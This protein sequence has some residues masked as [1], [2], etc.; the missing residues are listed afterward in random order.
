M[1][2]RM[3]IVD[4]EPEIAEGIQFLIQ[5]LCSQCRVIDLAYDGAEG[6]EKAVALRPDIILTD[7]RMPE[8]DG[9]EMI[10]RLNECG[11]AAKY[12]VLSGYAEFEYA[13]TAITLGVR[14]FITKP[15]EEQ[16][17]CSV[18]ARICEE[19]GAEQEK[20]EKVQSMKQAVS[21][22]V[23][24]DFLE[25]KRSDPEKIKQ[26]LAQSGFPL[27]GTGYFCLAIET[28]HPP[29][30]ER[31]Q[32]FLNLAGN[33]ALKSLDL[34][35]AYLVVEYTSGTAVLLGAADQ[36]MEP[37]SLNYAVDKFRSELADQLGVLPG[38]GMGT[39]HHRISDLPSSLE[40]ARCALNYKILKGA[41]HVITYSQIQD[42]EDKPSLISV[43]DMKRLEDCIDRLDDIGCKAVVEEIFQK[44]NNVSEL[45]L[46][47]L[48]QLSLNLVLT[49]LRKIPFVQLRLNRYLG[50][51]ILSLDSISK[52]RTIEQLQNWIVNT[53][54]SMNEVMLKDNLPEKRDVIREAKEYIQ[55]NFTRE[56][57]L[58]EI[59]EQFFI[60]PY[61][62]SQLFKRKTGMTYQNY[63]ISLRVE[64]A[65]K[66]LAETD[67][68]IY[69]ICEMV[70]Y[71]NHYHFNKIFERSEGVRPN[72]WRRRNQVIS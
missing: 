32:K 46:E 44:I 69:E 36:R 19:L 33:R 37:R 34:L 66:L 59:S 23:L 55:K 12:I 14:E 29:E 53:L 28:E 38:I 39:L 15:V 42:I 48:Q 51:N 50:R 22:Y 72:E 54:R 70:G 6:Y 35:P 43:N 63:L 11:F 27:S 45:N 9:L 57:G 64:R 30:E 8:A 1:S 58:N 61:Y 52:F 3:L 2:Y 13:R 17:L 4:D 7:I 47:D 40:E 68:K 56:I 65:K 18:I 41:D 67:L 31:W 49:G 20:Q 5:H 60:N 24:K 26:Q 21:R 25:Q 62:F 10:R 71:S 16:E